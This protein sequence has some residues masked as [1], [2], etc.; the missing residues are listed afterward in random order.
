[1]ANKIGVFGGTFSPIHFG[2]INSILNVK[3]KMELDEVKVIPAFQAPGKEP[4]EKPSAQERLEL[5]KLGLADYLDEVSVESYEIERGG[6]SYSIDTIKSL[7]DESPEDL[8]YL[9]IGLDQFKTFDSWKDFS[10]IF[11][12]ANVVVT[13]R[14]GYFFPLS[15]DEFP[16]GLK[17]HIDTFDGYTAML[18]NGGQISFVRLDDHDMSS[19]DIR[20]RARLNQSINRYVPLEVEAYIAKNKLYTMK[21]GVDYNSRDLAEKIMDVLKDN[22][23]INILGFD[24]SGQNQITEFPIVVSAQSKRANSTLA[25]Q[26][27]DAVRD[28]LGVKPIGV[29]GQEESNWIVIDYGS[30]MVHLF[31]EYLRYE[32]KIEEIWT[33]YPKL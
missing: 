14:P 27:I 29:D 22:S 19:S 1:M 28:D 12:L 33:D 24:L 8:F 20:K 13:S 31:Y 9:I 32:Y 5:V 30:V 26:V 18:K 4:I 10:E 17:E 23:G 21:E 25:E 16:E 3:E 15:V 11:N 2:H 7:K 6:I